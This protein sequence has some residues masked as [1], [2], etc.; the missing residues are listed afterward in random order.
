MISFAEAINQI[1]KEGKSFGIE[2]ISLS[3]SYGRIL[4]EEVKADRDYPPF[5]RSAMDGFAISSNDFIAHTP[6]PWERELHAGSTLTKQKEEQVI[7][8]MTGSPVPEGFD[9]V[10]KV[11]DSIL[12]KTDGKKMVSFSLESVSTWQNIAKQGEDAKKDD[13]LL[14]I[15]TSLQLS[16]ISLLASLGKTN[17][18]V[19]SAPKVNILSTGNEVVPIGVT[20]LPHQIRDSNSFTIATFL[21]KYQ[22]KPNHISHVPDE[23]NQMREE[24][25]QGLCGDILILSGGVSMGEKDLVPSILKELGVE[26]IFHKTAIKPG[27]PIWFGKKNNTFVFGLPGNPFSVQ[28]CLRIFLEPFLRVCFSMPKETYLKFPLSQ[29]KKKKHSL[30]EFF[31]VRFQTKEKTILE[32]ISF[33]GSGDIK[34]GIF[35][36]GIALFPSEKKQIDLEEGIEFLPW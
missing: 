22:I 29:L 7:R 32:P 31:P 1:T 14:P 36:D 18:F 13:L 21:R 27:K 10:I 20:P 35:S 12:S 17:V 30:T 28:T 11:E 19:F 4:A 25:K 9:A 3:E 26:T 16:E 8:I 24:I 34:A 15:G 33:N 2:S 6:F 23:E 5:H